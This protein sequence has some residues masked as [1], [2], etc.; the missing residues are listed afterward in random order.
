MIK[1]TDCN[2]SFAEGCQA[3]LRLKAVVKTVLCVFR[4]MCTIGGLGRY[5]GRYID[6]YIGFPRGLMFSSFSI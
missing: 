4:I 5:S 6:C 1:G 3:G 2:K